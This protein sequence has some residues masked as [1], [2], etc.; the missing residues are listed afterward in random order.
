[1]NRFITVL[2]SFSSSCSAILPN[3]CRSEAL[4]DE[5]LRF[6]IEECTLAVEEETRRARSGVPARLS[7]LVVDTT[8][9]RLSELVLGLLRRSSL[10]N[11]S[12]DHRFLDPLDSKDHRLPFL[13]VSPLR[14]C[15]NICGVRVG[16][17]RT[18]WRPA[19]EH[20]SLLEL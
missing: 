19:S 15:S 10:A 13:R 17:C 18:S 9:R 2:F 7:S 12:E 6:G 4:V 14:S 5:R 3:I 11:D 16:V 8:D 1:M 20:E